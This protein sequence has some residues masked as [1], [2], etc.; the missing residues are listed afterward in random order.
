MAGVGGVG[1]QVPE[2]SA[3]V[4]DGV[5]GEVADGVAAAVQ[6]EVRNVGADLDG[7]DGDAGGV[8]VLCDPEL[9]GADLTGT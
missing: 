3:V 5:D 2:Q 9:L 4:A 6:L 1:G 8:D 7:V